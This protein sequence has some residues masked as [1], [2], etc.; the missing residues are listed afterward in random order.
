MQAE[1]DWWYR[2]G[3]LGWVGIDAGSPCGPNWV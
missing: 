1:G 3:Y 2:V